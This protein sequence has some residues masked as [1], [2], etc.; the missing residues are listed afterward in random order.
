MWTQGRHEKKRYYD[1]SKG[2]QS[3]SELHPYL[4]EIYKIP[5]IEFKIMIV[6]KLSVMQENTERQQKEMGKSLNDINEKIVKDM[7][8]MKKDQKEI[9]EMKS[10]VK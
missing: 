3:H 10:S 7:E 1:P 4:R 5:E 8:L 6:R 2:I 9:L